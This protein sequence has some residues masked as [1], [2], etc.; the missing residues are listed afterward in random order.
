MDTS[1]VPTVVLDSVPEVDEKSDSMISDRFG[2][3]FGRMKEGCPVI[4]RVE[5]ENAYKLPEMVMCVA[6]LAD[7]LKSIK[8]V[9]TDDFDPDYVSV[10]V[11]LVSE[12]ERVSASDIDKFAVA[13][14]ISGQEM[15]MELIF[16]TEEDWSIWLSGLA[17]LCPDLQREEPC[18]SK[19]TISE[20]IEVIEEMQKQNKNLR[21]MLSRYEDMDASSME[22][23]RIEN[24]DLRSV[25]YIRDDTIGEMSVL[26][27]SL[28]EKQSVLTAQIAGQKE[29]SVSSAATT[30]RPHI[31]PLILK[32]NLNTV[33]TTDLDITEEASQRAD[34]IGVMGG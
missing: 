13:L 19:V 22:L 8:F 27:Q 9:R 34:A 20:L 12:V 31:T 15:I 29:D 1:N 3:N 7:D 17:T 24:A 4:R 16:A 18:A 2:S 23:L 6:S 14:L 32:K 5:T 21:S 25:L 28:I 11:V 30:M 10:S 26:V 33:S